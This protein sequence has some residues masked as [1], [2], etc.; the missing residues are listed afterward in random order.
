MRHAAL[1]E[2]PYAFGS[3]YESE[4]G[5]PEASWR[6]RVADWNRFIA[7]VDGQVVGIVGAGPGN[8]SGT[9]ALTSLWVDPGF[10]GRG[11]GTALI[12]AV[13]EWAK[14]QGLTQVLL[15]VTEVNRSAEKL[16]EQLG[17]RRTGS[18]SEVRPGEPAV[19][20]EMSKRI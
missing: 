8:F 17:F 20:H 2:A 5:Y 3:T 4:A 9:V 1:K 10:R 12:G 14:S 13:E 16:Y 18:V 15:W 11:V 7:E 6:Q 19:E